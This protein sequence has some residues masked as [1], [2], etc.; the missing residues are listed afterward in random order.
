MVIVPFF[1]M[2]LL[3]S[4]NT[5]ISCVGYRMLKV[6][7]FIFLTVWVTVCFDYSFGKFGV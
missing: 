2:K 5:I 3:I 6:L 1:G 7:R 4:L